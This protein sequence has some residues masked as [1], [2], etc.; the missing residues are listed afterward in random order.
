KVVPEWGA[1]LL[2]MARVAA[3]AR[4]RRRIRTV[5]TVGWSRIAPL[6][7]SRAEMRLRWETDA[8]ESDA[9][10][11]TELKFFV[12]GGAWAVLGALAVSAL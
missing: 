9:P 7:V 11:R 1:T 4:A 8:A 10:V 12:G 3:V 2:V 6:R 5:R